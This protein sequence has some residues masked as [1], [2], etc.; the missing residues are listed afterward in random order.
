MTVVQRIRYWLRWKT[1]E[2]ELSDEIEAHRMMVE[3]SLIREGLSRQEA[4]QASRRQLGNALLAREQARDIW[5]WPAF[6]SAWQDLRYALRM[7]RRQ[8]ALAMVVI[9]M[10]GLGIG[11]STVVFSVV[12]S[13]LLRPIAVHRPDELARVFLARH[14]N[15]Q[16][17]GDLSW[18]NYADVRDWN[19]SLSGLAGHALTWVAF[20][21][22]DKPDV[23]FGELVTGNYFDV[24]GLQPVLGRGF[25]SMEGRVPDVSRVVVVSHSLW[26]RKFA[27]S[28]AVLGRTIQLNGQPFTVIGVAPEGFTGT[29]FPLA[30]DFWTPVSVRSVLTGDRTWIAARGDPLLAVTGR[31]RPGVT[32]PQAQMDFDRIARQLAGAYPDTNQATHLRIVNEVEGRLGEGYRTA[33]L[34]AVFVLALASLVLLITC[35]NVAN[36]LLG[37]ALVRTREMAIR[38]AI[39][40]G[41]GRIVRQVF[42][43][44]VLLSVLGGCLGIALTY[45]GTGLVRSLIPPVPPAI[46]D[47]NF[48]PDGRVFLWALG[49]S[50]MTGFI[51]GLAPA[52]RLARTDLTVAIKGETALTE[53]RSR[54]AWVWGRASELLVG[55][56]VC[57]SVVILVCAGL[58]LQSLRNAQAT[59]PGFRPDG[60]VSMMVSPGLLRYTTSQASDFYAEIERRANLLPGVRA[61]AVSGGLLLTTGTRSAGPVVR[62]G[63][64]EPLPNR[65]MNVPYLS[66]GPGYFDAWGA[67]LA[68]GRTF[69]ERDTAASPRVAVVNQEFAR[70]VFGNEAAALGKRFR[71]GPA[72]NRPAEIVGIVRDGKYDNLYEGRKAVVFLPLAQ[73]TN[74]AELSAAFLLARGEPADLPAL[75]DMLRHE[76]ERLDPRVPVT[77]VRLGKEHLSVALLGPRL[78][79]ALAMAFGVLALVLAA[80]G[81]YS[82]MSHA[83]SRRTRELGIR[84]AI[85]ARPHDVTAL[86]IRQGMTVVLVALSLGLLLTLAVTRVMRGFL[87]KVSPS[88][89]ATVGGVSIVLAA[90]ALIACYLPARRAARLHPAEALRYE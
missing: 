61:A 17:Y 7:L 59:D 20:G 80:T 34:F 89:P 66:V 22:E 46:Q 25:S 63:E 73:Q 26:Q 40:A 56:Q 11:T 35:A 60:L 84:M 16:S 38:T 87:L 21:A 39:G 47:F 64:P 29:K 70:R 12:N 71:L 78:A 15:Q 13:I 36:L 72:T 76:V 57:L 3:Q 4:E 69:T 82:V 5:I 48:S 54:L 85:G 44:S 58:L 2:A 53:R 65:G 86:T 23:V 41:R 32:L 81:V 24:L 88:D 19:T 52:L 33:A 68:R 9:T 10:L 42:I 74:A 28:P 30:V 55:A 83:V 77:T 62:P 14:D 27:A 37:R 8:P 79:S 1:R 75:A 67:D 50:V 6:A 51:F 90:V 43:E 31:L 45:V 49:V 18:P